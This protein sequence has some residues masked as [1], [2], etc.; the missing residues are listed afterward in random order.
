MQKSF[1][2][3]KADFFTG[4]AVVLPAV[5]SVAVVIWLFGTVANFTDTLLFFLPREWTHKQGGEA[6]VHLYWSVLALVLAIVFIGLV[7]GAAR[8]YLGKQMIRVA[9]LALMR[10]PLLNRIYGAFKQI[11]ETL[12][13]SKRTSFREVVLVEFPRAGLWSVGF[14]TGA[15]HGEVQDKTKEGVV[16]VFVPTTPNPTTGFMVVVPEEKIVRL[17]MSVADG[18]KFIVSLGSVGPAQVMAG[19]IPG[20]TGAIAGSAPRPAGEVQI[21]AAEWRTEELGGAG[22]R[23]REK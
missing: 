5:I 12:T 8:Y 18:V 15:R 10:V 6:S 17:D 20:S 4:L 21:K 2:Y 22:D 3:W 1:A 14:I 16:G 19:Q 13:S 11:N 23:G 7:G 9:D